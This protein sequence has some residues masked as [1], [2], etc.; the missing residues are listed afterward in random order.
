MG[1][2]VWP[3]ASAEYLYFSS[4]D[5]SWSHREGVKSMVCFSTK[6]SATEK[7]NGTIKMVLWCH[8]K[9]LK[10]VMLTLESC[11]EQKPDEYQ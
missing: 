6:E 8:N 10:H 1:Q 3:A 2:L 4:S 7:K 5:L 11:S 9:N